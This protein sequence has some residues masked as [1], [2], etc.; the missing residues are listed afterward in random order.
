MREPPAAARRA[1][2]VAGARQLKA[3][4][5]PV[6]RTVGNADLPRDLPDSVWAAEQSGKAVP[7]AVVP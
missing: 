7:T 3:G 5:D 2:A 6:F 4:V 1:S